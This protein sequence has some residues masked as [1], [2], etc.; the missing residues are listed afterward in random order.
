MGD[1]LGVGSLFP[2]GFL[3][4]PFDQYPGAKAPQL[5]S[6]ELELLI[7]HLDHFIKKTP[8]GT[9]TESNLGYWLTYALQRAL[10]LY[11]E[12]AAQQICALLYNL[13]DDEN[14]DLLVSILSQ[15]LDGVF[16]G[17]TVAY[18][19][20]D[21]LFTATF[22]SKN[23]SAIVAINYIFSQLLEK[24][25]DKLS[26][27]IA[28]NI[29]EGSE[30]G[31]NAIL[32][33]VRALANAT[34]ISDNQPTAELI[35]EL[36]RS[37]VRKS[38]GI[39]STALTEEIMYSSFKGKSGIYVLI[40]AIKNA[41][42]DNPK[43]VQ[44][45]SRILIDVNKMCS[46]GLVDSLCKIH[47]VGPYKGEHTLHVLLTSLVSAAY[48][49]QNSETLSA[50][51]DAVHQIWKSNFDDKVNL[52]LTQTI[53]TGDH[54]DL[55][56]IMM[57]VRALTAAIDHQLQIAPIIEFLNNFIKSDPADLGAAFTHQAPKS[58]ISDYT[59][60]PLQ[61]LINALSNNK[62]SFLETRLQNTIS[63]LASSKSAVEMSFSL[64]GE[65]KLV[66]V[67]KVVNAHS[68][69]QAEMTR[70]LETGEKPHSSPVDPGFFLTRNN[71][72]KQLFFQGCIMDKGREANK[73][74]V[75]EK[76]VACNSF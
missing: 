72:E 50:L 18:A 7:A 47:E 23:N 35:A 40:G 14:P 44:I 16:E 65:P 33:L 68:L 53:H 13:Y 38:P 57:I 26:S 69:T 4:T 5:S 55:N 9:L 15:T 6:E 42:G 10:N 1:S 39:I 61:L 21:N 76:K 12:K 3:T 32:V 27:V 49:D 71:L 60:S 74:E 46:A 51:I 28:K 43:V 22:D 59:L 37:F 58:T 19:W 8:S 66:F 62:N 63:K 41:I 29:E 75:S 30:K 52:A 24:T 31:K 54:V 48:I 67:K 56:G 11:N 34:S 64:E 70:L 73:D 2:T 45:L 36:L 17:Q 20:M 25:G